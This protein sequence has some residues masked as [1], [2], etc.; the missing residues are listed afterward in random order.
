MRIRAALIG[1]MVLGA[2]V[3]MM[4]AAV[5]APVPPVPANDNVWTQRRPLNIAHA[6]GDLEAPHETL[7]AYKRAV[8]VGADAL[9][10]DIRL[11]TDRQVM[12]VHDDT[13][14]RTTNG[15]GAVASMT[16][17][18]LQALD[19]AYWFAPGC[20]SCHDRPASDYAFRG[21]R[22]GAIAPPRGSGADDFA[23][24]TLRQ[25]FE[26]FP[27]RLLDIEIKDGP[28][29]IAAADALADLIDEYD[30]ADQVVVVSFDD[31]I[32]DHFRSVAPGIDTSPGLGTVT[33]WF[34]TRGPLPG[35][36]SLQVPP[37][38]SGIQVVSSQFVADAHANGLAV[39]V[40]FNGDEDDTTASYESLLD[41]G[42]DGFI[43]GKPKLLQQTLDARAASFKTPL[44]AG[45]KADR[46]QARTGQLDVTCPKRT[47]ARCQA[48]VVAIG[49][50]SGGG[51]PLIVALGPSVD[52]ARS[53]RADLRLT[54]TWP[55]IAWARANR[56]ATALVVSVPVNRDTALSV[57]PIPV[58]AV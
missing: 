13:V 27:D 37:T 48:L 56:G 9:E 54:L 3:G 7:Y 39:Y 58:G 8:A 55:G 46:I 38:Y 1:L 30:A 26:Q 19:N 34:A 47:A 6:G 2:A 24:P 57:L 23:I 4:P 18:E 14:D 10:L 17:A 33:S 12:V 53:E 36:T 52:L 21:V 41:M 32:L 16:A 25:V 22:T 29:G 31:A 50:R 44:E 49:F 51:I 43:T 5:A 42:V 45:P 15:T 20:W 40:W 35:Q 28:D 11:S